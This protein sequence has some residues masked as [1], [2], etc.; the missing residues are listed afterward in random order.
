MCV[1][2]IAVTLDRWAEVLYSSCS[3]IVSGWRCSWPGLSIAASNEMST[4]GLSLHKQKKSSE[5]SKKCA[6]YFQGRVI[7]DESSGSCWG[8]KEV[9]LCDC[10][11]VNLSF[12]L[13]AIHRSHYVGTIFSRCTGI[14]KP[15]WYGTSVRSS[16]SLLMRCE[17]TESQEILQNSKGGF[18]K[19]QAAKP[20]EEDWGLG[21][22]RC[23]VRYRTTWRRPEPKRV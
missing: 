15:Q 14:C 17:L 12:C 19:K 23:L 4:N 7:R 16:F 3:L 13:L 20:R 8:L 11:E 22:G 5:F 10:A 21:L 18:Q 9:T 6:L 1:K 2:L